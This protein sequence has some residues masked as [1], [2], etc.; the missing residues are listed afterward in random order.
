MAVR[1]N[2][3]CEGEISFGRLIRS[4]GVGKGKSNMGPLKPDIDEV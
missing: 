3:K 2:V 1:M 4:S